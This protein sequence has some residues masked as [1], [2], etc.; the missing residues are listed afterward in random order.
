LAKIHARNVPA[1]PVVPLVEPVVAAQA[2]SLRYVSDARPG[3]RRH[4]RGGGFSYLGPDGQPVRDP[5]TLARIRSLA[6]PPAWTKVWICPLP[7][8]HLQATGRD[9]RGRK[10]YRYHP[11][12]R[13]VRDAAKFERMIWFGAAL[14]R[15]RR[16]VLRDLALAGMPRPKVLATLV[17]LLETTLIRVGNEEYVRDNGSFGL[18]TFRNRHAVVRGTTTQFR[19]PGKSGI[20]H[21]VEVTDAR[22]A[23]VVRRCQELP[24]HELFQYLDDA[25]EPQAVDSADVNAYLRE[26]SG[27]DFT[28]KDF[29]TW[30]GTIHA[31]CALLEIGDRPSASRRKRAVA[32]AMKTVAQ[33]LGNTPAICR[34][35]YVHPLILDRYLEGALARSFSFGSRRSKAASQIALRPEESSLLALLES[36]VAQSSAPSKAI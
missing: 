24:G 16:R 29:R 27:E 3:I 18:T 4:R 2:A 36:Q 23:R 17:L 35:C 10:Q 15:I 5:D 21:A 12:W 31:A 6:I 26:I 28:A 32:Q 25:G 7:H 19:F 34:K 22:L 9:A 33:R 14:P 30:A 8:G 20:V 11:R 1:T 13:E